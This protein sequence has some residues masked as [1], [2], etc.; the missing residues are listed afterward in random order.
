MTEFSRRLPLKLFFHDKPELDRDTQPGLFKYR[1]KYRKKSNW[2]PQ[3]NMDPSLDTNINNIEEDLSNIRRTKIADN[4]TK[5]ERTA[6]KRL[7]H[8]TDIVI[9]QADKGSGTVVMDRDK[10]IT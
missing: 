8:R 2:T 4:L 9:K 1:F 5:D 10:Y 7:S 6:L 3:K